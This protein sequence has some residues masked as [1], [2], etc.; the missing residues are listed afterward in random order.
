M[1][2]VL[3]LRRRLNSI[4]G[5][6]VANAKS[7]ISGDHKKRRSR[8]WRKK[9]RENE[10]RRRR[11]DYIRN[12]AMD[13]VRI[14]NGKQR[15]TRYV[16]EPIPPSIIY[17]TTA[18]SY[19][20]TQ[21]QCQYNQEEEECNWKHTAACT[22]LR[23][24]T[25]VDP[26]TSHI[27]RQHRHNSHR[28]NNWIGSNWKFST[29]TTISLHRRK[30]ELNNTNK[31][32]NS[33]IR[34]YNYLHDDVDDARI[35]TSLH[36]EKFTQ[37]NQCAWSNRVLTEDYN[38]VRRPCLTVQLQPIFPGNDKRRCIWIQ[39]ILSQREVAQP[40]LWLHN[41]VEMKYCCMW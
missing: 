33:I 36:S 16:S 9:G 25:A 38:V 35:I 14:A 32:N 17:G 7:H 30:Q 24:V 13:K 39:Q 5:N 2:T 11:H 37:N 15:D 18:A 41:N 31:S 27:P 19:H 20:Y 23:R 8:R 22:N 40:Y 1:P 29:A 21:S 6:I 26:S 4:V 28:N 10:Q 12:D 3:S 34:R